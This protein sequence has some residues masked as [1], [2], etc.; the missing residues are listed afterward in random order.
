MNRARLLPWLL[1][2]CLASGC[3]SSPVS[4]TSGGSPSTTQQPPAVAALT[5]D[6]THT[7][8]QAFVATEDAVTPVGLDQLEQL[9]ENAT[10]FNATANCP[11]GGTVAVNGPITPTRNAQGQI[12]AEDFSWTIAFAS[13]A[14]DGVSLDG[15]LTTVGHLS[16]PSENVALVTFS[17]DGSNSFTFAGHTG[18]TSFS[19]SNTLTIDL[20]SDT[21]QL[22]VQGSASIEYPTGQNQTSAPCA[23]F[24]TGFIPM[25]V[26]A[27]PRLL[28]A[29]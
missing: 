9:D 7:L 27:A 18:R 11:T 22:T 21:P 5:P 15:D 17:I 4:P 10:A 2:V 1:P 26:T 24:A 25:F 14:K 13:C 28:R 6:Q 19:C 16:Q 23:D 20:D 3:G 12:T 29:Y 8:E